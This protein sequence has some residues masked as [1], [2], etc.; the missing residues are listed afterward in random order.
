MK[1]YNSKWFSTI[2]IMAYIVPAFSQNQEILL[3]KRFGTERYDNRNSII[4]SPDGGC[5][6]GITDADYVLS[7]LF[8]FDPTGELEWSKI[9]YEEAYSGYIAH[10]EYDN[11]GDIWLSGNIN[12]DLVDRV[13]AQFQK[14]NSSGQ[15]IYSVVV[16]GENLQHF[17]SFRLTGDGGSVVTGYR[18]DVPYIWADYAAWLTRFDASGG[19]IWDTVFDDSLRQAFN[20]VVLDDDYAWAVGYTNIGMT[21]TTQGFEVLLA[22][23]AMDDGEIEWI[24]TYGGPFNEEGNSI[25]RIGDRLYI[26]GSTESQTLDVSSNHGWNDVWVLCTDLD[27]NL[28]WERSYG[29][30]F[31]DYGQDIDVLGDQLVIGAVTSSDDGDI[32]YKEVGWDYW[33]FTLDQSGN[34]LSNETYGG[35][36][37]DWL[38]EIDIGADGS[39]WVMGYTNSSNILPAEA[40]EYTDA[41]FL[42]LGGLYTGVETVPIPVRAEVQAWPN[43]ADSEVFI[44]IGK[45]EP[46]SI[47]LFDALGR[48][49]QVRSPVLVNGN[50]K[51]DTADLP[52]GVYWIKIEYTFGSEPAAVKLLICR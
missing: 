24:K 40:V 26:V 21:D 3:Q 50:W 23:V 9:L 20:D 41:W 2:I 28:L 44:A 17:H 37:T 49:V 47:T 51:I 31:N 36:G 48:S 18:T 13:D 52:T 16:G 14:F 43:P 30:T 8:K 15:E 42:K 39:V 19:I 34:I 45:A 22:K 6:V 4:E 5:L 10:L 1:I 12:T 32:P 35:N 25:V 38:D 11:Q 29:G 46:H 33:V 27:G 7:Q